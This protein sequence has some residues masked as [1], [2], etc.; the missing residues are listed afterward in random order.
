MEELPEQPVTRLNVILGWG[1]ELKRRVPS[2]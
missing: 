2:R 1:E